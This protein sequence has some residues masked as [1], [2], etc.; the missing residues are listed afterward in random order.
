M[1]DRSAPGGHF[2]SS[3]LLTEFMP[4]FSFLMIVIGTTST[5]AATLIRL[6]SIPVT[7]TSVNPARSTAPAILVVGAYVG[8]LW[9]F[10]LAPILGAVVAGTVVHSLRGCL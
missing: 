2:V 10:W 7:N 9:L 1:T 5:G 8:Q 6:I 4:N 3:R